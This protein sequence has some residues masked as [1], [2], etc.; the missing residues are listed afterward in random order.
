MPRIPHD[1]ISALHDKRRRLRPS[2]V[3]PVDRQD[4]RLMVNRVSFGVRV[5]R[6]VV[7]SE[8]EDDAE[9][10]GMNLLHPDPI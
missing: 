5:H 8:A 10:R 3:H 9:P 4:I 6:D 1:Q 7:V 2:I